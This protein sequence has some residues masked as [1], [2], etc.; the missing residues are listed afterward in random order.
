M[1]L[2]LT[3]SLFL[4]PLP[5][6]YIYPQEKNHGHYCSY[7]HGKTDIF[8]CYCHLFFSSK[9]KAICKDK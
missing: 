1:L 3:H 8:R 7:T 4:F 5:T 2:Y 6:H 9:E